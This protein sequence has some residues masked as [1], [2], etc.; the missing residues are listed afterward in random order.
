M[1]LVQIKEEQ[2][3]PVAQSSIAEDVS[4]LGSICVKE[5]APELLIKAENKSDSEICAECGKNYQ[6]HPRTGNSRCSVCD[7]N[8]RGSEIPRR[9]SE[10]TH[11]CPECGAKFSHSN[12]LKRHQRVHTGEKPY[13][14]PDCG[15]S[16]GRLEH[17]RNHQRVHTGQALYQCSQCK[18]S[19]SQ[20]GNLKLHLRIHTGEKA[21]HCAECGQLFV[22]LGDLKQHKLIHA[23]GDTAYQCSQC[24]AGFSQFQEL[25]EHQRVHAKGGAGFVE[26]PESLFIC[27]QCG[28]SF[29]QS[30]HYKT[31]QRIHTGEKPYHCQQCGQSFTY[32]N[33]LSDEEVSNTGEDETEFNRAS[34]HSTQCEFEVD[35]QNDEFDNH[36]L[37]PGAP[38]S[39]NE[40]DLCIETSTDRFCFG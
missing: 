23:G 33:Q 29:T 19:F 4:E 16:Y 27:E 6:T 38:L 12:S 3:P 35:C 22:Q 30:G 21:Y 2:L 32:S 8:S 39:K 20:L 26:P 24:A 18:K 11:T 14:C 36:P 40:S 28:D 25:K 31:H 7:Q 37:Y 10:P 13:H 1:E 9:P 5:E 15:E 34:C 17:L